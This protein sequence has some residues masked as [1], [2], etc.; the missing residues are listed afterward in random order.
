MWA[1]ILIYL[2]G[3]PP[4]LVM[5]PATVSFESSAECITISQQLIAKHAFDRPGETLV[6][7]GCERVTPLYNSTGTKL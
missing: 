4:K 3:K 1:I 7:G 5:P 6:Y 2:I